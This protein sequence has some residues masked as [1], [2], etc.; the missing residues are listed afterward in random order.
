VK[1][2]AVCDSCHE[3]PCINKKRNNA[4]YGRA[5]QSNLFPGSLADNRD[6]ILCG[7]CIKA[8]PN[9]NVAFRLRW[10]LADLFRGITLKG[11][12][13]AFMIMIIGHSFLGIIGE[14]NVSSAWFHTPFAMLNEALS[15]SEPWDGTVNAVLILVLIPWGLFL[16]MTSLSSWIDE[17]RFSPSKIGVYLAAF[18]PVVATTLLAKSVFTP[19]SRL[20][21]IPTTLTDPYGLHT[22]H[23]AAANMV[24]F[25]GDWQLVLNDVARYIS[26]GI[27]VVGF[28]L[29]VVLLDR[30]PRKKRFASLPF[31]LFA[32]AF[33][34]ITFGVMI[35]SALEANYMFV[36]PYNPCGA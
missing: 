33:A 26:A 29:T 18:I 15:V 10:P 11:A 14:W 2:R 25:G 28:V 5:C 32:L 13:A 6:C 1:D 23:L 16:L 31:I 21:N 4:W 7:Q 20:Q 27:I 19:L 22:A 9:N 8:C 36:E 3:K 35:G 24:T 34:S 12:Q 17:R 30:I